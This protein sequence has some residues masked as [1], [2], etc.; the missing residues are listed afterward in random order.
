MSD[1]VKT[2]TAE[3]D[4]VESDLSDEAIDR[5]AYMVNRGKGVKPDKKMLKILN[6]DKRRTRYD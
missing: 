1:A 4:K 2:V 6:N 5:V 3:H